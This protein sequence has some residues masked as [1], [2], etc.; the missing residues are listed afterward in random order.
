MRRL[1]GCVYFPVLFLLVLAPRLSGAPLDLGLLAQARASFGEGSKDKQVAAV[2]AKPK[3]SNPK[4]QEKPLFPENDVNPRLDGL[5]LPRKPKPMFE[6]KFDVSTWK[7][8]LFAGAAAASIGIMTAV[9]GGAMHSG[10]VAGGGLALLGLGCVLAGAG[11]LLGED[12]PQ[13]NKNF[14]GAALLAQGVGLGLMSGA[15][16]GLP[17]YFVMIGAVGL[18][19]SVGL[20]IAALLSR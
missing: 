15:L 2:A 5:P 7:G 9:V 14:M 6:H 1:Q 12:N 20:S 13:F 3:P 17:W 8:L 16:F 10:A 11:L 18:M 19:A 4:V